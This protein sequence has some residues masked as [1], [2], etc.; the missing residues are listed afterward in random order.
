MARD[1][2]I[3]ITF[4]EVGDTYKGPGDYGPWFES[5]IDIH[6]KD[7]CDPFHNA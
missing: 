1:R 5:A 2:K 3:T 6:T 4:D 7:I